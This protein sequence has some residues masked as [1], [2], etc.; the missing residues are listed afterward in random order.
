[1]SDL[2]ALGRSLGYSDIYLDFLKGQNSARFFFPAASIEDVAVG[3]DAVSYDREEIVA[4]LE[5]QNRTFGTSNETFA[6][7]E[8]LK[9]KKA[10]CVFTS[11]QACLFGGP[12]LI[13]IK[14]LAVVKAARQYSEQLNRPVVP[15]FWIAGDD[16]DFAEVNHT[17]VLSRQGEPIRI[18]YETPPAVKLPTAEIRF[19]DEAELEKAKGDLKAALGNTDF[20]PELYDLI[21][22]SYMPN[23][24][25][26]TAFGRLMARLTDQYGL[27]LFSPGDPAIKRLAVPFFTEIL[28]KQNELHNVITKTNRLIEKHKY[29]LQVQKKDNAAHLF[30]NLV[31]RQP[32]LCERGGFLIGNR[33]YTKEEL[34]Q[35]IDKSPDR[36]SP[37]VMLRPV[38]QSYLFPVLT[39]KSGPSEIAYLAQINPIFALF[40]LAGPYYM[41]RP[42]VTF[43]EKRFEKLMAEYEIA[44]EELTGDIEQVINRVLTGSFPKNLESKFKWLQHDVEH[45]FGEFIEESLAFDPA[46]RQ[47]GIQM[48]NKID[49]T[50]K[51]FEGKVFASHKRKSK[52]TCDRL[53]RL[54]HALYP[55]RAL[56]ERILNVTYFLSRYGFGFV[57]FMYDQIDSEQMAHQIVHLE[58][59]QA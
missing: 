16:H 30:C 23:S 54:Q 22:S 59:F 18:S 17:Y 26:V 31:G 9:D 20:T 52:E 33:H 14:A 48:Y 3:L 15:V 25:F 1:M 10:L 57:S 13:I 38:L 46:L 8:K 28:N 21:N 50:L 29:H 36:V 27:I 41:A 53:Y 39:Q 51:Q 37:D 47:F 55:N 5:Q 35:F 43:L 34:S 11:Q 6:N 58:E 7:I 4:V 44:F 56:Q 32:V 19:S 12:L 2:I 40:G 49:F 45:R 42:S 24:T